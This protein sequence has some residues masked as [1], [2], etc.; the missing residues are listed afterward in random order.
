[1]F[2]TSILY[3][4]SKYKTIWETTTSKRSCLFHHWLQRGLLWYCT[5]VDIIKNICMLYILVKMWYPYNNFKLNNL[6]LLFIKIGS[7]LSNYQEKIIIFREAF[8]IKFNDVF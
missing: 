2:F 4:T 6:Y 1:L 5:C 3:C 8:R 7:Q